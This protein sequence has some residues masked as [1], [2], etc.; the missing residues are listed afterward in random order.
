M[1]CESGADLILL[2]AVLVMAP[3]ILAT[4]AVVAVGAGTVM[5]ANAAA[6]AVSKAIK[7]NSQQRAAEERE[8][9]QVAREAADAFS[10]HAAEQK[11]EMSGEEHAQRAAL[12][13]AADTLD[14]L[15]GR[16]DALAKDFEKQSD[17]LVQA[18]TQQARD[19][20]TFRVLVVKQQASGRA[21]VQQLLE[22]AGRMRTGASANLDAAV[23]QL[24]ADIEANL[25][26][27]VKEIASA[28][29]ERESVLNTRLEAIA[30][31]LERRRV[32][33]V[34]A[35]TLLQQGVLLAERLQQEYANS[36]ARVQAGIS[37]AAIQTL[38]Q[39]GNAL[40]EEQQPEAALTAITSLLQQVAET[41]LRMD[42]ARYEFALADYQ[43]NT[44]VA[45]L[46]ELI[47]AAPLE[48][49]QEYTDGRKDIPRET[50]YWCGA[51]WATR[52]Q[53]AQVLLEKAD[54]CAGLTLTGL[55]ELTTQIGNCTESLR[56]L[57][58]D[59]QARFLCCIESWDV[60]RSAVRAFQATGWEWNGFGYEKL[61]EQEKWDYRA[62][63]VARFSKIGGSRADL[64]L[65]PSCVNG[66]W[67]LGVRIDRTDSGVVD[68]GLRNTQR[69]EL[70]RA[71]SGSLSG[72]IRLHCIHG[73]EGKNSSAAQNQGRLP[74]RR[75][76]QKQETGASD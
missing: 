41:S 56:C 70:E 44:E 29:A 65:E 31:R 8:K 53:E 36:E 63:M 23:H 14:I 40:L 60:M 46:R 13:L 42:Q 33:A 54:D 32:S 7:E 25:Q 28:L 24:H 57:R 51:D 11:R 43:L 66:R 22:Q 35:R 61:D 18:V 49:P 58:T 26:R 74:R 52:L 34:Y 73:T 2:G 68:E 17:A 75:Q 45:A 62:P 69:K 10:R 67:G 27:G 20:E 72:K 1:S 47:S 12:Q 64:V 3:V 19:A 5:A 4:A 55:H 37:L 21:D 76:Q 48:L 16:R 39:E 71:F 9:A 59:A 15:A 6:R 50:A 38:Q 30:D